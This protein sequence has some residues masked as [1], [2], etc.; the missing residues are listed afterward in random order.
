METI[1][2]PPGGRGGGGGGEGVPVPLEKMALF[3]KNKTLIFYVPVPQN[4][5]CS[6]V[7]LIFRPL[8]PWKKLPL[9]PC[10]P[11]PLGGLRSEQTVQIQ[12][13]SACSYMYKNSLIKVLSVCHSFF[14][15]SSYCLIKPLGYFFFIFA[16]IYLYKI[17]RFQLGLPTNV[18]VPRIWKHQKVIRQV[19]AITKL[20]HPL[21]FCGLP[22]TMLS[23]TV[24]ILKI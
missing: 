16:L 7:P 13:S 18:M 14:N 4:C 17:C 5:L 10:S 1:W 24:K 19:I 9:F 3:P 20:I 15:Y 2:G 8:F 6:P 21:T 12:I 23:I 11:K 22:S